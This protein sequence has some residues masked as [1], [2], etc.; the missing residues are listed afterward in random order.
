MVTLRPYQREAVDAVFLEWISSRGKST[1]TVL[2]TGA[3][4]SLVIAALVQEALQQWP[5]MRFC[6]IT[7]VKELIQ[8]NHDE[9][10]RLWPEADVG[11]YSAGLKRRDTEHPILFCGIQ[12]VY[13]KAADLGAFDVILVDEAH[14]MSRKQGSMYGRFFEDMKALE[15][16][17]RVVGL[18]ATPYRLDS[19]RLDKGDD[20]VFENISYEANVAD[21][22]EEGFLSALI[23]KSTKAEI[24]TVGVHRRG[25][26]FIAGELEAAAMKGDLV[27]R[28]AEEI[29]S[30]A[31]DRKAWLA[32]CTGVD[33]AFAVRDALRASAISCETVTGETPADERDDIITR[34]KAGRIRCLTSVNVLSIGFNAPQVDLIAL[35][36]PTE[37]PGLYIQQVGRGFRLAPGKENCLIL[38][39]AGNV[40]KH[41]PVDMVK[42]PKGK[43]PGETGSV[44]C[45]ECPV[46]GT[47]N[48]IAVKI[49]I[50]C[51]YEWI[52]DSTPKHEA[53]PA[54]DVSILGRNDPP[55][56]MKVTSVTY[57][58]HK[59]RTDPTAP[60]SLRVTYMCGLHSVN[61]YVSLESQNMYAR[62]RAINFWIEAGGSAP[63]PKTV[64]EA[65]LRQ[66]ELTAPVEIFTRVNDAGF[67]NVFRH[68]YPKKD[69]AA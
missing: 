11:I 8:Q 66:R 60:P 58:K 65:L 4:K 59:K 53:K 15:P 20:R 43:K 9:L 46:C 3:G 31:G 51:D 40:R 68:V 44:P 62:G 5:T 2:P 14:L 33:H 64:D 18:T 30:R 50:E 29:V 22:I 21:L 57:Y 19:G 37:S 32:F 7:H 47:Y 63:T 41:G 69:V 1:L 35:L 12:S 23:S 67:E 39:F 45:R 26:E 36:R 13:N 28:A 48:P 24:S 16:E 6:M 54:E 56:G 61:E 25:G 34:F 49:C 10:L 55:K 42:D 27:E 38:D 17:L 52:T